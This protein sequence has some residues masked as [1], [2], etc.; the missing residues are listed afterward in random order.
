MHFVVEERKAW[1]RTQTH[2]L[3]F[4]RDPDFERLLTT[5][6]ANLEVK[7]KRRAG[8]KRLGQVVA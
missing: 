6:K 4:D 5:A 7:R 2:T 3:I 1:V 8:A